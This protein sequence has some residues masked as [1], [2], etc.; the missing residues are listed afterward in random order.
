[1][2]NGYILGTQIYAITTFVFLRYVI[3]ICLFGNMLQFDVYLRCDILYVFDTLISVFDS[4]V[5]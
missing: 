5:M 2:A 1:M 3:T 4:F